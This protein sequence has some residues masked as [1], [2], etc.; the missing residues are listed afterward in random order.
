VLRLHGRRLLR[1]GTPV[2][3][4]PFYEDV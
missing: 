3:R 2:P 1:R 4:E